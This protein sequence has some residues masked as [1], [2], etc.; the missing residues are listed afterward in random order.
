MH[1]TVSPLHVK[2]KE[3]ALKLCLEG[4]TGHSKNNARLRF[5]EL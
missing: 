1:I 4:L 2:T 3:D 5:T